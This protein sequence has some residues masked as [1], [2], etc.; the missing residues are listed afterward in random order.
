MPGPTKQVRDL[1]KGLC[2]LL[3][4]TIEIDVLAGTSAGGIN[5]TL[6]A[7]A[8]AC[9]GDLG[10]IRDL[11][12]EHGDMETLLR[13]PRERAPRSLLQ[14]DQVLLKGISRAISRVSGGRPSRAPA[15]RTW[16]NITTTLLQGEI[17]RFTDSFG[18]T[19]SDSNH[20][21]V[22]TFTEGDVATP[23][24]DGAL[25]LAARSSA[26]FPGAFEPA[27]VPVGSD[28]DQTHPD[29]SGFIPPTVAHYATDGG[30]LANQPIEPALQA[31]FDSPDAEDPVRRASF[32]R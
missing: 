30:Q 20:V 4:W 1:Y 5:A 11:W 6:L 31:I 28:S 14:G 15:R 29:M 27:F 18:T 10:G 16:L 7:V 12:L 19:V 17:G 8:N 9:G 25:A 23:E 26:S 13:D 21:G 32:R 2:T 22:F 24:N 3:G